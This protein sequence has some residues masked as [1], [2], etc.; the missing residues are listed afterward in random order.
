ME[1]I[2][3]GYIFA[4]ILGLAGMWRAAVNDTRLSLILNSGALLTGTVAS[5]L[6]LGYEPTASPIVSGPWPAIITGTIG[7]VALVLAL[8]SNWGGRI[9]IAD[10]GRSRSGGA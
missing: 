3:F 8:V 6:W 1:H 5:L 7:G 2:A 4:F 10:A 9:G